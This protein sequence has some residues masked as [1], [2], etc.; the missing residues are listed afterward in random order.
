MIKKYWRRFLIWLGMVKLKPE[1]EVVEMLKKNMKVEEQQECDHKILSA[2]EPN[3]IFYRCTKCN[4]VWI[5]TDAMTLNADR[6]PKFID[7]LKK[8]TKYKSSKT[9]KSLE[10]HKKERT[11]EKRKQD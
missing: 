7:I 4:Q 10:E 11:N 2:L 6:L 5:I 8:A 9:I 3:E 1:S